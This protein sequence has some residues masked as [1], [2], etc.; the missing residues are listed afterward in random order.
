M[1]RFQATKVIDKEW[2]VLK[3]KKVGLTSLWNCET[4]PLD[5]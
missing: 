4:I 2:K 3:E 5:S 1:G